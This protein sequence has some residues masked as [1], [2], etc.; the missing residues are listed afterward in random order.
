MSSSRVEKCVEVMCH[1]G[2]RALWADIDAL[3]QGHAVQETSNLTGIERDQ[4]LQELKSIM[5]VYEGSCEPET[6]PD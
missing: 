2:C 3:E 4:V 1:K 5:A 6:S